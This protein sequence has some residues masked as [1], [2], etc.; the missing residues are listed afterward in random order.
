MGREVVAEGRR[1]NNNGRA[2]VPTKGQ[3]QKMKVRHLVVGILLSFP[4]SFA[5]KLVCKF[6]GKQRP[7]ST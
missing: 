3:Q 5:G 6:E 4:P 2:G 1:G 7:T